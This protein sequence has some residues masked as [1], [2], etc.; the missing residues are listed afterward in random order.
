MKPIIY[1]LKK[2]YINPERN[3]L[4]IYFDDDKSL[5]F[6]KIY[7]EKHNGN[8]SG[9]WVLGSFDKVE[10]DKVLIKNIKYKKTTI[11]EFRE[12]IESIAD[13]N[14]SGLFSLVKSP[15]LRYKKLLNFLYLKGDK[16]GD[17]SN[18]L[19]FGNHHST[20]GGINLKITIITENKSVFDFDFP[21]ND[22]SDRFMND[23]DNESSDLELKL[24]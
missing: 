11:G 15:L 1:K 21:G 10:T 3:I 5:S 13:P 20:L 17:E 22:L 24:K 16:F 6:G 18:I 4:I 7:G 12:I 19:V 8:R 9:G 14:N 23:N 2:R